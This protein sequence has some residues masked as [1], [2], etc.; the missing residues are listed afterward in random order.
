MAARRAG[1]MAPAVGRVGTLRKS[2][3]I[4]GVVDGGEP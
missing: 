2:P 3:V 4:G 1:A